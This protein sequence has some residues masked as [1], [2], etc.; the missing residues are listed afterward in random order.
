M[1]SFIE[2]TILNGG[3]GGSCVGEGVCDV[4]E[5]KGSVGGWGIHMNPSFIN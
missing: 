4:G 1:D 5:D 3:G 2:F